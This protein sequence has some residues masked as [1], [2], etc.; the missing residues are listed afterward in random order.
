VTSLEK[1]LRDTTAI[2]VF[3][4]LALKNE[5]D[6]LL[7]RFREFHAGRGGTTLAKL[8]ENFDFL[9]LKVIS[10]LQD[11]DPP[12][13]RDISTS[14]EALW[15]LLAD[16]AKFKS[17]GFTGGEDE[18]SHASLARDSGHYRLGPPTLAGRG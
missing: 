11:K 5:V 9:V 17:L 7:T 18:Q 13:A 4:K 12:L 8:R 10:L 16:P 3:T 15:N 1:R 14:R 2:G 6:D